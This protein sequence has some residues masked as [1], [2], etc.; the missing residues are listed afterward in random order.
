MEDALCKKDESQLSDINKLNC[1]IV[2]GILC[3]AVTI[4]RLVTSSVML[5]QSD[6]KDLFDS[7]PPDFFRN[8]NKL[9]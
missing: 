6:I 1:K 9:N 3:F 8:F 4:Q 5:T 2:S 7:K